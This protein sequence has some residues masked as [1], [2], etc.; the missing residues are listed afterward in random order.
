MPPFRVGAVQRAGSPWARR[1]LL[2]GAAIALLWVATGL[3]V[4]GS[5]ADRALPGTHVAGIDLGGMSRDEA[6]REL[7]ALPLG[8]VTLTDGKRSFPVAADEVG[9]SIDVAATVERAVRAGR[10]GALEQLIGGAALLWSRRDVSPVY[11]EADRDRLDAAIAAIAARFDREPFAGALSIDPETLGVEIEPPRPG[12]AVARGSAAATVLDSLARGIAAAQLPVRRQGAP[13]RGD[14]EAVADRAREFLAAPLR[15]S[16]PG[17][18]TRLGARELASVL[19]LERVGGDSRAVRLGVDA[20][21]LRELVAALAGERD[22]DPL[23]ASLSAPAAP[24]VVDEQLDLSWRARPAEVDVGQ[25]R[26]GRSLRQEAAAEAIADAVRSGRHA[27]RLP[28][29]RLP[30]AVPTRAARM[31]D[32]LIGTFTTY[33]ACCEPRVT[34]IRLIADAVDGTVV[35]PGEQFSLNAVAGP[36]TA[37]KGYVPAPFISDGELVDAVG[38][39]VSQFST[40]IFNAAYFAGLEIDSRQP[41]SLYISRYPPGREATLDYPSI[42]LLWTNDTEAPVLVR[43]STTD[44]SVTVSLYGDNGGRRVQALTGPRQ[45]VAGG[46]FRIT[47]TR[48]IRVRGGKTTRES[49]TTTYETPSPSG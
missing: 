19:A 28:T 29:R 42:E 43:S 48:V 1:A 34:N 6:S 46:D 25:D 45:P 8:A 9:I 11:E 15:L 41:H 4:R 31:V 26:P 22:R 2:A 18:A 35:A 39:G 38:G 20:D 40:T 21:R 24:L 10:G 47:V 44:T 32:S 12:R 13:A 7:A 49:F 36:R 23:D 27:A 5:H 30:A 3:V 17:G 14:V 16:G 33:F 37:A